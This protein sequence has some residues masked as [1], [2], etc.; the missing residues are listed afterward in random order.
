MITRDADP[1]HWAQLDHDSLELVRRAR[2]YLDEIAPLLPAAERD[3]A[4]PVGI[5]SGLLDVGFVRGAIGVRDGV[6]ERL[7]P[8]AREATI[9]EGTSQMQVLQIGTALLGVSAVR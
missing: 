3:R 2:G 6:A 7:F 5:I 8:D 1:A 9:G 4:L